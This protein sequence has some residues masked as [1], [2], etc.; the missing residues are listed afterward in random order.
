MTYK[1]AVSRVSYGRHVFE[2]EAETDE[3]AKEKASELAGDHAFTQNSADY[4]YMIE[5]KREQ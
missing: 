3:E 1:V 5:S 4:Y 2:V